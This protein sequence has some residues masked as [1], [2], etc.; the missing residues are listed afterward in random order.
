MQN[1]ISY[2]ALT[3][4]DT[5]SLTNTKPLTNLLQIALTIQYTT[6]LTNTKRFTNLLQIS[7]FRPWN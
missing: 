5:T 3:I 4:Q 6:S 1:L 7:N 2:N